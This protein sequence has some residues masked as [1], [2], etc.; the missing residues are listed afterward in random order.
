[1]P[2]E[3]VMRIVLACDEPAD[4]ARLAYPHI[5]Y[6]YK[7]DG[8]VESVVLHPPLIIIYILTRTVRNSI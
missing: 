6:H 5:A 1:M 7:L 4:Q 2:T 3:F 8:I